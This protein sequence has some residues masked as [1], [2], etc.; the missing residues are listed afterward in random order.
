MPVELG[1][2]GHVDAHVDGTALDVGH[3]RQSCVLA[4]L[5]VDANR[6]VPPEVLLDRVWGGRPPQRA[7]NALAG[8]VSRLRAL[9]AEV[10]GVTIGRQ[11]GGYR[12][13]VDLDSVD[14][15]RFH[16]LIAE[17][18]AT[19][20][21]EARAALL[22]QALALWRAEPFAGL[23]TPWV[24]AVRASLEAERL[25]VTLDRNDIALR[26]DRHGSVL[27]ELAELVD[28][29]PLDER[30]AAQHML[31]LYRCGRQADA[32]RQFET[33]RVGLA[34]ELGADPGPDLRALHQRILRADPTLATAATG[35]VPV[36]GPV[37]RQ[38]P[39]P[40]ASFVGRADEVARLD[41]A[42]AGG[43]STVVVHAISGTPG[44]GKTTL[45]LHWAHRAA[46]RFPDGQ[47]YLNLRAFGSKG[48]ALTSAEALGVLLD[49]LGVTPQ[50]IPTTAD[51]RAALYRS[52]LAGKRILVLLDNALDAEQVR[53]LLP[54]SPGCAAVV[55]SRA[56]LPALVVIDG[57]RP[58]TL[59]VLSQAESR[60]LLAAR[61]G[62]A[63]VDADPQAAADIAARCA[64][65]PL[66]LA[67]VAARVATHVGLTLEKVALE[68]TD[69]A[70][71]LEVLADA[72]PASDVRTVFSWSYAALDP[73]AARLFRRLGLHPGPDIGLAAAASLAG[74]PPAVVRP[75]MAH[76]IRT[77]L[78]TEPGP[79]R[80][81][82]H[83]L[84]RA[85]AAE[86]A[87]GHDGEADRAAARGRVL[88]HYVHTSHAAARLLH[89]HRDPIAL[90]PPRAGADPEELTDGDAAKAWLA[91]ERRT[92]VAVIGHAVD[93][94]FDAHAWRLGWALW[95]FLDRQ[96]HWSDL[97]TA[98][99]Y[100]VAAAARLADPVARAHSH[101]LLACALV[102]AER[103]G[104]AHAHLRR[105]LDLYRR[106]GDRVGQANA[107]NN[108]SSVYEAEGRYRAALAH[109][110]QS[111]DLY[112]AVGHRRGH[113]HALNAVGWYH[114]LLG[115]H[116]QALDAC[117]KAL[118]RLRDLGDRVGEAMTWHSLGH[119]HFQLGHHHQAVACHRHALELFRHVGDRYLEADTLARIGD[120]HDVFGEPAAA[121]DA[122]REALSILEDLDHPDA[123][124]V[125]T[126]L[127]G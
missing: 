67:I 30:L 28:Q 85:Y 83:D 11:P 2:L 81:A 88:D 33:V 94:G 86:L 80:F 73:T 84:L 77:H 123:D 35:S 21:D 69:A 51:G 100:A 112:R 52:L 32:L 61:I 126:K 125:R 38:L 45:A 40:P 93:G 22:D 54:G 34:E 79:G 59:D 37:P 25:A 110:R 63:A 102:R 64:G 75:A 7:R 9:F 111:L 96:G 70:D 71:A 92:L 56:A 124:A 44:V 49:S 109:G 60:T 4:A 19:D 57:A 42:H 48:T 113:A 101:R 3:A 119:A 53:P 90:D 72:E 99:R 43:G 50:R 46:G 13:T 122:W 120:D 74:A 15:H 55:T 115:Q 117:Q 1:L 8:Y 29:H 18:R 104:D 47:L 12:L 36:A 105:A 98:G 118:A 127:A 78:V 10:D 121:R 106:A 62:R 95:T 26:L 39:A 6:P 65:L 31:A 41:A 68:L 58:L 20:G 23:D 103:H 114:A 5:L 17:A 107:H 108:I 97:A 27:G 116:E 87:H 66:A 16:R 89:P 82:L 76:L 91:R 14:L 24:A